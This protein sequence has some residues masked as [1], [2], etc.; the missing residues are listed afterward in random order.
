MYVCTYVCTYV[1]MCVHYVCGCIDAYMYMH[2]CM[3]ACLYAY[4][5]MTVCVCTHRCIHA[6]SISIHYQTLTPG[7]RS[8]LTTKCMSG[9]DRYQGSREN[10]RIEASFSRSLFLVIWRID[11]VRAMH[12]SS[13]CH[14]RDCPWK[15]LGGETYF[16][17]THQCVGLHER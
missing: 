1:Y 12:G 15:V 17:K 7:I 2:V 14:V 5:C 10:T 11:L 4:V 3:H 9:L 13:P 6:C 8:G 16:Y